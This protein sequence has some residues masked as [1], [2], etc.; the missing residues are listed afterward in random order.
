MARPL[1]RGDLTHESQLA[2]I[3]MAGMR[4]EAVDS[5]SV[6]A[7]SEETYAMTVVFAKRIVLFHDRANED[8]DIRFAINETADSDSFPVA[9]GTYF[10]V[11]M[12]DND[13]LHLFNASAGAITVYLME[14]R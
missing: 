12:D 4:P 11:E 6:G 10:V 1:K 14:I 7:S 13:V 2:A 5:V 3:S 8:T 9:A